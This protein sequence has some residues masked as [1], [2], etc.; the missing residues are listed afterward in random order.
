MH[1]LL[2]MAIRKKDAL[3]MNEQ[4]IRMKNK[5]LKKEMYQQLYLILGAKRIG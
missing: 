1:L 2:Y 5:N 4:E 3:F